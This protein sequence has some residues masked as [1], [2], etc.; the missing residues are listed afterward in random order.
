MKARS[1]GANLMGTQTFNIEEQYR[2]V[3]REWFRNRN[4]D[5]ISVP[6]DWAEDLIKGAANWVYESEIP[7]WLLKKIE[8]VPNVFLHLPAPDRRWIVKFR[9]DLWGPFDQRFGGWQDVH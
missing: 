3:S 5:R 9:G 1:D 2:K 7:T 8:N 6:Q 4:L